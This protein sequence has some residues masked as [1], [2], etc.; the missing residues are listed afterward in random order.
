MALLSSHGREIGPEDPLKGQSRSLS[1]VVKGIFWSPLSGLNG[2]KSP[3]EFSERT[4]DCSL[5]PAGK[6]GPHLAMTVESRGFSGAVAGVWC[7]SRVHGELREPLMWRQGS[8]VSI[9][10]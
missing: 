6:E 3:V 8:P 10:V 7:F 4:R 2:V 9:R 5:D 1:R